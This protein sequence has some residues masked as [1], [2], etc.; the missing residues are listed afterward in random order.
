M[1][2]VFVIGAIIFSVGCSDN[3]KRIAEIDAQIQ[4]REE[5]IE[6]AKEKIQEINDDRQE[7]ISIQATAET[8]RTSGLGSESNVVKA[9][10]AELRAESIIR[11][12][13]KNKADYGDIIREHH[14]KIGELERERKTLSP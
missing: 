13:E 9:R 3:S 11:D 2:T 10:G 6:E 4:F 5:A 7:L 14:K 8:I 12:L 1:R